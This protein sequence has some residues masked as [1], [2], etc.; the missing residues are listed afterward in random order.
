M[1]ARLAV[2]HPSR[3]AELAHGDEPAR[4]A[5]EFARFVDPDLE[6]DRYLRKLDA[7]AA[8]VRGEGHLAL[9]RVIS[10]TQGYG[11]NVEDYHNPDNSL[12]HRV[13]DSRRGI[14]ISL[15][16]VWIEVGRR[17]GIEVVGVGLPGHFVVYAAGQMCDPFH[18]GEAI[19]FD[20]AASLV[21]TAL[22]GPPRLD[23]SWLEPVSSVDLIRRM[24]RNLET[25]YTDSDSDGDL[26][27]VTGCLEM[28]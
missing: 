18:Y 13:L 14:P 4:A 3:V 5:L 21:A 26:E 17:C 22:G 27:W 25:V 11:G 7:M 24:L 15:S 9:R 19:G 16:L 2:P 20:E 12:L 23:Q 6:A 1:S 8:A 10:I 28:L